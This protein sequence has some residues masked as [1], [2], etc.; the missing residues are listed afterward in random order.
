MP[1]LLN[2]LVPPELDAFHL[3]EAAA[4]ADR[5]DAFP[6]GTITAGVTAALV[7]RRA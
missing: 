5:P 2:A 7:L 6:D 3:A 1:A 4:Q